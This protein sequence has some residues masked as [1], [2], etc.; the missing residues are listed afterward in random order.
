MPDPKNFRRSWI[1]ARDYGLLVTNP[2]GNEAFTKGEKSRVVVRRGETFR[3][4]FAALFHASPAGSEPDL[5]AA[6]GDYL[7]QLKSGAPPANTPARP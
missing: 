7:E 5:T 4:G 2:F 3:L 1:H 6:Y